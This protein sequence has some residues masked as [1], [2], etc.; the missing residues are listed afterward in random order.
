MMQLWSLWSFSL[1]LAWLLVDGTKKRGERRRGK[2]NGVRPIL[3]DINDV[4]LLQGQ[5]LQTRHDFDM[6]KKKWLPVQHT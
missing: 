3:V 5:T 4:F 1:Y 2:K 6:T